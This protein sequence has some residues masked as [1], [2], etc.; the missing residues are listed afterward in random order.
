MNSIVPAMDKDKGRLNGG[1]MGRGEHIHKCFMIVG[2][3]CDSKLLVYE[4]A[5]VSTTL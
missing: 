4:N 3:S 2:K 1:S 5:L